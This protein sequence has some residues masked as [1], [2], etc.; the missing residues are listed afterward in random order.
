M[1]NTYY[2]MSELYIYD[3]DLVEDYKIIATSKVLQIIKMKRKKIK[4]QIQ[5]QKCNDA[6]NEN[7]IKTKNEE[8]NQNLIIH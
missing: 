3:D 6:K 2:T 1:L 8:N 5:K 4:F 7:D